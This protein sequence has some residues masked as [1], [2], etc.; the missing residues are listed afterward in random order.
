MVI[1]VVSPQHDASELLEKIIFFVGRLTRTDD[2][3]RLSAFRVPDFFE[4]PANAFQR[5]FPRNRRKAAI[6]ANQRLFKTVRMVGEIESVSSPN[7]LAMARPL[8]R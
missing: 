5:L 4:S 6:L 8:A 7:A 2:A 1:D 3:D